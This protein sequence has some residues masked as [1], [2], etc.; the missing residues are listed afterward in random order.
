MTRV[1]H[2]PTFLKKES[3]KKGYTWTS[4]NV[5]KGFLS[6]T[7][8]LFPGHPGGLA[9]EH[10]CAKLEFYLSFVVSHAPGAVSGILEPRTENQRMQIL[11]RRLFHPEPGAFGGGDAPQ[12]ADQINRPQTGQVDATDNN[13]APPAAAIVVSGDRSERERQ[14]ESELEEERKQ[15]KKAETNAAHHQD[16]ARRL[17]EAG[18]RPT[19]PT[20]APDKRSSLERWY[21]SNGEDV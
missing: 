2:F 20:P 8:P 4:P 6:L 5:Y 17:K 1:T 19:P 15:R 18:L 9:P 7:H 21:E 12:T 14:L 3:K 11:F 16:E 13:G 10:P